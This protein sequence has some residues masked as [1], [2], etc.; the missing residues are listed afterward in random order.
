MKYILYIFLNNR[1]ELFTSAGGSRQSAK[2][3]LVVITDG[4]S[5]DRGSLP[6]VASQAEAKNIARFAIGVG[7]YLHVI[8]I[9]YNRSLFCLILKCL[10]K[11]YFNIYVHILYIYIYIYISKRGSSFSVNII[12]IDNFC[13]IV[14]ENALAYCMN[15]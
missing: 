13:P 11:L 14:Q 7:F 4:V 8:Q 6:S 3:I 15:E 5:H 1:N 12:K 9:C 10:R 2:K